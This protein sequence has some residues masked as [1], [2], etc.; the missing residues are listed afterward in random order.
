M[1]YLAEAIYNKTGVRCF[2]IFQKYSLI[3]LSEIIS[4]VKNKAS[5]ILLDLEKEFGSLDNM[6]IDSETITIEKVDN[7]KNKFD[8]IFHDGLGERL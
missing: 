1:T 8:M 4:N 6:D 2:S 7:I 5:L 3:T